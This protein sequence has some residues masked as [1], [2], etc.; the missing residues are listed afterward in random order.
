MFLT[1][2]KEI[3]SYTDWTPMHK[4]L[5]ATCT[6]F[7][8]FIL[9]ACTIPDWSFSSFHSLTSHPEIHFSSIF[10]QKR[11]NM[12]T[13]FLWVSREEDRVT[14]I[15][16]CLKQCPAGDILAR[17]PESAKRKMENKIFNFI[18]NLIFKNICTKNFPCLYHFQENRC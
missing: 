15:N 9:L 4:K 7:L 18:C 1:Q 12:G 2:K 11:K 17:S 10:L 13:D 3:E 6:L 8:S 5:E 16:H 14:E